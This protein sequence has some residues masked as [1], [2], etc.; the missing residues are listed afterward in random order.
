MLF[1]RR[2]TERLQGVLLLQSYFNR[3]QNLFTLTESTDSC[4]KVETLTEWV[5]CLN[6]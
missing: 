5:Y 3:V 1:M 2:D 6:V 4:K